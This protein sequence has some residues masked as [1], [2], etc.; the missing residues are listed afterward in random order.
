LIKENVSEQANIHQLVGFAELVRFML[1]VAK[2][3][4][5]NGKNKTLCVVWV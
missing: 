1:S 2:L 5:K 4:K 3:I